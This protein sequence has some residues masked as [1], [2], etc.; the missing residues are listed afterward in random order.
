VTQ[1]RAD[2]VHLP[3]TRARFVTDAID[4]LHEDRRFGK[5][6]PCAAE[7]LWNQRSK[8]AGFDECIDDERFRITARLIDPAKLL[9]GKQ[10]TEITHCFAN[11]R[12]RTL[13]SG[14]R[15]RIS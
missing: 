1:Q 9:A 10:L 2:V 8:P 15:D 12:E 14:L 5:P 3:V 11:L 7:T 13:L 6:E 4:P